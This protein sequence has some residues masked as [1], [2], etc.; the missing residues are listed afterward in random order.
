[1]TYFCLLSLNTVTSVSDLPLHTVKCCTVVFDAISRLL[2]IK[3][4]RLSA[5]I[6]KLRRLLLPAMS[7]TKLPRSGGIVFITSHGRSIDNTQ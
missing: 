6:N 4:C 7:V 5:T 2:V 3:N 1:M